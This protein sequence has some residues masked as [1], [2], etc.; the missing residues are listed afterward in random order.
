MGNYIIP[1]GV[2]TNMG[3]HPRRSIETRGWGR[4]EAMN[5]CACV[6]LK[7][8]WMEGGVKRVREIEKMHF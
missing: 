5:G 6:W 4:E 1:L 2:S 3:H 8:G 7:W